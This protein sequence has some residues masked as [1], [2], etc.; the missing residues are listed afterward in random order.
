MNSS[1]N[2]VDLL[3]VSSVQF[4]CYEQ[5]FSTYLRRLL[6]MPLYCATTELLLL[7]QLRLLDASDVH[8]HLQKF[9]DSCALDY[10]QS[11]RDD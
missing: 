3:Q 7:Q 10:N 4:M 6:A 2:W 1:C 5:A 8:L 9:D 11:Q